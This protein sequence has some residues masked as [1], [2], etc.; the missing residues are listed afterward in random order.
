M[1]PLLSIISWSGRKISLCWYQYHQTSSTVLRVLLGKTSPNEHRLYCTVYIQ[2]RLF[3]QHQRYTTSTVNNINGTK[4]QWYKTS[5]S[6]SSTATLPVNIIEWMYYTVKHIDSTQ[7]QLSGN[8]QY[9]TVHDNK[10][11]N[12]TIQ[13]FFVLGLGPFAL[14]RR[15]ET[16]L[17]F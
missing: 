2:H 3:T 8:R 15:R 6:T 13:R 14:C 17:R 5:T 10:S 1:C 11:I 7:H 9:S 12:N 16:N 4:H